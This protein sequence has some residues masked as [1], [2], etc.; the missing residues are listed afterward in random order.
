MESRHNASKNTL[1]VRISFWWWGGKTENEGSSHAQLSDVWR[2]MKKQGENHQECASGM[3]WWDLRGRM[4]E[5][6]LKRKKGGRVGQ[7]QGT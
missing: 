4:W 6:G 1:L 5:E 3:W 2:E 7:G